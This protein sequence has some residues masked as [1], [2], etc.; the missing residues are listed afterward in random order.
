MFDTKFFDSSNQIEITERFIDESYSI[1][2]NIGIPLNGLFLP[3]RSPFPFLGASFFLLPFR[4]GFPKFRKKVAVCNRLEE[5]IH[6]L[7]FYIFGGDG[8]GT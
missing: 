3:N 2:P 4:L 8:L 6:H 7:F 1:A 5:L